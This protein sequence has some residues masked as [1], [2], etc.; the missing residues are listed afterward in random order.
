MASA[1]L[2]LHPIR[3]RI[4][5]AF[6][7]GR[8]LTTSQLQTELPDVPPA[9]LYR[10]VAKLADA[11]VLSIADERRIRGAVER[12]YRLETSRSTVKPEE[13]AKLSADDHR[14][15]FFTFLAAIIREFDLYLERGDIDLIRDGV[16][17]GLSAMWL[18]DTEARKL[19]RALNNLLLP[20]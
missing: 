12:T 18:S 9:S 1:D 15:M 13:L 4:L 20:A 3:L 7:G 8:P 10:H 5:Q 11:G 6:L 17:Y 16:S 2:L 19:A 14:S